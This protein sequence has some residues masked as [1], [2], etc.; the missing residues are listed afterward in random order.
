MKRSGGHWRKWDLTASASTRREPSGK[1]IRPLPMD[2]ASI[3]KGYGVDEIARLLGKNGY[4]DFL[5]EIGGE[6]YARDIER[7]GSPGGSAS[8]VSRTKCPF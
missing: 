6:V 8:I 5:V 3:A 4:P 2:L 1:T 7:M